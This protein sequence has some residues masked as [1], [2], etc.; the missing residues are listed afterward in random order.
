[1]R[2]FKTKLFA[3]F[4][5][6]ERIADSALSEAIE[7]AGQGLI[8]ADLGGGVIKQRVARPGR[9][10]RGG[11]RTL[12]AYRAGDLAVFLF[13]FSKSERANIDDEELADLREVSASWL[14]ADAKLIDLALTNG[15]LIEVQK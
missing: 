5:R 3:K 13:G 6:R 4:A 2:V 1:M 9:G 8:D 11:Y 12:I 10:R 7:W 14:A 15:L